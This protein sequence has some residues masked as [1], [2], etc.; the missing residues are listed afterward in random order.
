MLQPSSVGVH[1]ST[2]ILDP[3]TLTSQ[4][5]LGVDFY[6]VKVSIYLS[7]HTA[8]PSFEYYVQLRHQCEVKRKIVGDKKKCNSEA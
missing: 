7:L 2:I 3:Q 5:T 6:Q 4:M 1:P 8:A